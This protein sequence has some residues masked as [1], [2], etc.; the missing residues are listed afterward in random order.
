MDNLALTVDDQVRSRYVW[1]LHRVKQICFHMPSVTPLTRQGWILIIQANFKVLLASSLST[2]RE[3]LPR[4]YYN[5]DIV[6]LIKQWKIRFYW[7]WETILKVPNG[8]LRKQVERPEYQ[9]GKNINLFPDCRGDLPWKGAK[10]EEKLSQI[11]AYLRRCSR[12][13]E[14][15]H[16][17]TLSAGCS[18]R[19]HSFGAPPAEPPVGCRDYPL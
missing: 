3:S 5:R 16:A 19:R 1:Q 11:T 17:T 9:P 8:D 4:K 2:N 7:Q 18:V 14:D 12:F 13:E 6:R 15:L 10:T